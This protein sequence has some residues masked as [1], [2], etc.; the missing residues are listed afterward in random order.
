MKKFN[1]ECSRFP[2]EEIEEEAPYDAV[3]EFCA[4]DKIY[5]QLK[6]DRHEEYVS[7]L[8]KTGGTTKFKIEKFDDRLRITKL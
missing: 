5:N 1:V 2:R 6:K 4:K 8:D 3:L 7:V